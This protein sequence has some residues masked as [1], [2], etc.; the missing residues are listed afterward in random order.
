MERSGLQIGGRII[1]SV[2]PVGLGLLAV[3]LSNLPVS[4]TGGHLP[5]P[6]LG[7]MVVYY[8]GLVRPDLMTPAWAFAIG[9]LEDLLAPGAPGVWA[10][11]FVATYALIDQQREALASLSGIGALLGFAT[12][13]LTA[14]GCAY[15]IVSFLS[16]RLLPLGPTLAEVATTVILFIPFASFLGFVQ[17]KLVGASRSDF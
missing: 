4:L 14:C 1:G 11:S 2:T 10:L 5:A 3:V 8:W 13:A 12:A 7:L 6:L 17:Q 16:M 15:L 9:F